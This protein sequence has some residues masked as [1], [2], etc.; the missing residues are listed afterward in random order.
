MSGS[1]GSFGSLPP[2][3]AQVPIPIESLASSS[4]PKSFHLL[5]PNPFTSTLPSSPPCRIDKTTVGRLGDVDKPL[6]AVHAVEADEAHGLGVHH[7]GEGD[8]QER[9]FSSIIQKIENLGV[10]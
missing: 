3:A 1:L 6:A 5:P 10:T 8:H 4:S 9:F 2:S 7:L